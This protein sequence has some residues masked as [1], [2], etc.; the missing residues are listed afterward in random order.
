MAVARVLTDPQPQ[1]ININPQGNA[2]PAGVQIND[3]QPVQFN[4][5]S[6][7]AIS[8]TFLNTARTGQRVFNDLSIAAGQNA[9]ESPLV[10]DVTVNYNI[11]I[12]GNTSEP[13]AIQ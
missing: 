13:Y 6:G 7:S 8:I 5:N 10:S 4:N 12:G 1:Q 11:A 9:S 2:S 3:A